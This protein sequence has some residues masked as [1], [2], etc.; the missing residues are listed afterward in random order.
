MEGTRHRRV[1]H[2]TRNSRGPRDSG[3][4]RRRERRARRPERGPRRLIHDHARR[5]EHLVHCAVEF[6]V[7]EPRDRRSSRGGSRRCRRRGR[8]ARTPRFAL[9]VIGGG[10]RV[11]LEGRVPARVR[12]FVGGPRRFIFRSRRRDGN[13]RGRREVAQARVR[14]R[15]EA[16]D[17]V[18][19]AS[20]WF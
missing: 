5:N 9:E 13:R 12:A 19:G 7:G 8:R 11:Q 14:R 6:S 18:R 17:G 16:F 1:L 20:G 2:G 4:R 3:I 10:S 15:L